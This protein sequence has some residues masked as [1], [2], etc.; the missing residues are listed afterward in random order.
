MTKKTKNPKRFYVDHPRFGNQPIPSEYDFSK[1]EIE[2]AHWSYSGLKYFPYTAIPANVEKQNSGTNTR[3][4]YVD[5]AMVCEIC[6]QP[7]IFFAQE[8]KYW[9]ETLEFYVDATCKR[10]CNCRRKKHEVSTMQ[11]RYESLV[12]LAERSTDESRELKQIAL[13]LYQLGY[14]KDLAKI[15]KI[16]I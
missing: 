10:C 8:Q 1:E 4:I 2:Q 12:N 3:T 6:N 11:Q 7:F 5:I 13:E 15:N 14:I 9:F 16:K